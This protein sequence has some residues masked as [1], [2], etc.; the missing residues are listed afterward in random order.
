MAS[1]QNGLGRPLAGIGTAF[2]S[3]L[4][5]LGGSLIVGFL[6]MQVQQAQNALF[7]ELEESLSDKAKLF[8]Y[9]EPGARGEETALPYVNAA[10]HE[11]SRAVDRLEKTV[12]K[13]KS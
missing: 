13:I 6:G 9:L 1:V 5:G 10:A 8:G 7:R 3:S 4:L 2:A 11:L 12:A